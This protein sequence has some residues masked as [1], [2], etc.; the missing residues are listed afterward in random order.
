MNCSLNPPARQPKPKSARYRFSSR[1]G[2]FAISTCLFGNLKLV[3]FNDK[4]WKSAFVVVVVVAVFSLLPS[5]RFSLS[6]GFDLHATCHK[7][8]W[9]PHKN[10]GL[11]CLIHWRWHCAACVWWRADC[12][13]TIYRVFTQRNTHSITHQHTGLPCGEFSEYIGKLCY[14]LSQQLFNIREKLDLARRSHDLCVLSVTPPSDHDAVFP[15][16][17]F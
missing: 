10:R 5:I 11:A 15:S 14:K 2:C 6:I 17:C 7:T 1:V 4:M 3:R 16:A 9:N 13:N 8:R 12:G